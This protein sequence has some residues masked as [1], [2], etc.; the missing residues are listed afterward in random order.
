MLNFSRWQAISNGIL[1][2]WPERDVWLIS[3]KKRGGGYG[4]K[5][6]KIA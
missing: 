3:A 4:V 1:E 5:K 2:K 6:I